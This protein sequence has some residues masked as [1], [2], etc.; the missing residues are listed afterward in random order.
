MASDEEHFGGF[1]EN[2]VQLA[3]ENILVEVKV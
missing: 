3:E 2:D 1:D